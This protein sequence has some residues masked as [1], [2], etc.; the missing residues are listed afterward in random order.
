MDT[1]PSEW[2]QESFHALIHEVRDIAIKHNQLVESVSSLWSHVHL[3]SCDPLVKKQ[4]I[5][6]LEHL[7]LIMYPL[8]KEVQKVELQ[9][10]TNPE[11]KIPSSGQTAWD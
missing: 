3:S 4:C 6:E 11:I 1:S 9:C 8:A 5:R 2:L 10:P 7:N